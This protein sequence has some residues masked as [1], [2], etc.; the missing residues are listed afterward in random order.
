MSEEKDKP[1]IA[2]TGIKP[3]GIPHLGNYLGSIEPA[4]ELAKDYRAVY[5]IADYHAITTLRDGKLVKDL[6]YKLAATWLACGLDPEKVI[7]YRQSDVPE[8]T[9]LAWVLNC[10]TPKG[11]LNRGHAFKAAVDKNIEDGR[12]KEEG[13]NAGIFTYPVLMAADILLFKTDV[14][15]MGQD[16]KQH[17]EIARDIASA[18]NHVHGDVLTIPEPLIRESVKTVPGI[19]GRKMSK[20]YENEIPIFAPK[21]ELKKK[22]MRIV[23]DS[24]RPE[25]PKDPEKCNVFNIFRH[26]AEP[27]RVE[28]RAGQYRDGGVGYGEMKEELLETLEK[29]FGP[30]REA[31][32][33]LVSDKK[34]IDEVLAAGAEKARRVG[35]RVLEKVRKKVGV[36]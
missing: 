33:A 18:F 12:D 21:N 20:S 1:K 15:P 28:E 7:F 31:Y 5:F 24:L 9:E 11:L 6:S 13:V 14:V 26:F 23:T 27:A 10:Y 22:V 35:G 25:D 17:L 34:K 8:V 32:D 2:L 3:T 29:V 36:G 30:R 19:D 16:Q 4:L